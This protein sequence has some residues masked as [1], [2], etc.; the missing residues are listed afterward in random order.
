MF[1][2]FFFFKQK[3]AYEMRISDWS[4]DVCSSDL[5]WT[6]LF[7]GSQIADQA[8]TLQRVVMAQIDRVAAWA[9]DH[10]MG[11]LQLDTKTITDNLAGTVGRVTAALGPVVGA[12]T[13]L[14][15]IMV[16]G[17]F[18]AIEPRLY[19]R[20]VAWRLTGGDRKRG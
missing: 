7:A 5:L 12:L 18:L 3:T 2:V 1:V 10:G 19:E 11:N 16:L 15:M 20:G 14:V 4:S 8:A 13:S 17:L 6:I 9:S